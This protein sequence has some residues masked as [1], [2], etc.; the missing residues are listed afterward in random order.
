MIDQTLLPAQEK[1]IFFSDYVDVA[2]AIKTMKVRGAPAIG[3]TAALGFAL[4]AARSAA[5]TSGELLAELH[6]ASEIL[7]AT[8]PTAVNLFWALS[9]MMETAAANADSPV[10][11]LKAAVIK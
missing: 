6:R 11:K 8:R 7:G 1:F 4:A 9:R 5:E 10:D 2:D 3:V